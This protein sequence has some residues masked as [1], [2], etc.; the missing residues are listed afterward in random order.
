ML[1]TVL[2]QPT[3]F[4]NDKYV[5][6]AFLCNWTIL[7]RGKI[8]PFTFCSFLTG[9]ALFK[10]H[11]TE[12]ACPW[13]HQSLRISPKRCSLA[14]PLWSVVGGGGAHGSQVGEGTSGSP[15]V[16]LQTPEGL[17]VLPVSVQATRSAEVQ[18]TGWVRAESL[19]YFSAGK[20]FNTTLLRGFRLTALRELVLKVGLL[21]SSKWAI[22]MKC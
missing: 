20:W 22:C 6:N 2:L 21:I 3:F 14:Q 11:F 17:V 12:G 16:T 13:G 1:S 19:V 18:E 15:R 9:R 10:F 4:S 5:P 8:L 7:E